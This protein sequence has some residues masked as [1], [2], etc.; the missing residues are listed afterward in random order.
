MHKP[1]FSLALALIFCAGCLIV[2][3]LV[4]LH[5]HQIPQAVNLWS[6]SSQKTLPPGI[7]LASPILAL[8]SVTQ[9]HSSD[10]KMNLVMH[11]INQNGIQNLTFT[12][13]D[14]KGNNPKVIFN[15]SVKLP[16][17]MM[18]PPNTWSPDN[19]N[20]F[21]EEKSAQGE[22]NFFVFKATG[23]KFTQDDAYLDV[24][25]LFTAKKPEYALYDATGWASETLLIILT[26]DGN[27]Q[28]GPSYWFDITSRSFIQLAR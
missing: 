19:K 5:Y 8:P 13:S 2:G 28:K 27:G 4:L 23:E 25:T 14:I 12:V 1:H 18:I 17:S 21:L 9:V 26:R 6:K 22:R 20:L 10:G 7:I 24:G 16:E 3:A 15:R 11:T